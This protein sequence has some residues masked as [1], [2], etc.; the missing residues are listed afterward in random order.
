MMSRC[1]VMAFS[2]SSTTA[3]INM[4]LHR[5]VVLGMWYREARSSPATTLG[6]FQRDTMPTIT[7]YGNDLS[8]PARAARMVAEAVG[9]DVDLK[10]TYPL[11]GECKKP[12]YIKMNPMHQIPTIN[13]GGFFL[14]ESHAIVTY[15]ADKY[16]KNENLYPKDIL[17]RSI[18]HE[19]LFFDVAFYSKLITFVFPKKGRVDLSKY[20]NI[21]RWM[22]L[23]QKTS[24]LFK[25]YDQIRERAIQIY[26]EDGKY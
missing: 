20:K 4:A 5:F 18:V 3:S 14:S 6:I 19:R 12:E 21:Q 15:L 23:L 13:D 9:L 22:D 8:P 10:R 7:V 2:A 16:A 25:K 26:L 1:F 24:P 11:R 17:K